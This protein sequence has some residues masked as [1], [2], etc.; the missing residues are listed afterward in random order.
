MPVNTQ[1]T[2]GFVERAGFL[3]EGSQRRKLRAIERKI[4]A[5]T[6]Q[7]TILIPIER[8]K[9]LGERHSPVIDLNSDTQPEPVTR[10]TLGYL[11]LNHGVGCLGKL[12]YGTE[13]PHANSGN[14]PQGGQHMG[15]NIAGFPPLRA[16]F[17]E[18]AC[19]HRVGCSRRPYRAQHPRLKTFVAFCAQ[20]QRGQA[21]NPRVRAFFIEWVLRVLPIPIQERI[22]RNLIIKMRLKHQIGRTNLRQRQSRVWGKER[23]GPREGGQEL[24]VKSLALARRNTHFAARYQRFCGCIQGLGKRNKRQ[25]KT[26]RQVRNSRCRCVLG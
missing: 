18:P 4:G 24:A 3:N 1:L 10:I 11:D 25:I 20:A 19:Q 22:V 5:V 14:T 16:A 12:R 6:Q 8:L 7:N 2:A 13:Q 26:F 23:D 9:N 17:P 21:A 15:E